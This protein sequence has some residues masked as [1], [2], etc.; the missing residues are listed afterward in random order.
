M[1]LK[2]IT[3][4]TYKIAI[5][6]YLALC[7]LALCAVVLY[8]PTANAQTATPTPEPTPTEQPCVIGCPEIEYN[9][10]YSIPQQIITPWVIS[11]TTLGPAIIDRL[12]SGCTYAGDA[13]PPACPQGTASDH[14]GTW[15]L[16]SGH[17]PGTEFTWEP[18][19]Y[20]HAEKA[21]FTPYQPI[22]I[23]EGQ[24]FTLEALGCNS[25]SGRYY[26]LTVQTTGGWQERTT[27]LEDGFCRSEYITI[28]GPSVIFWIYMGLDLSYPGPAGVSANIAVW[29]RGSIPDCGEDNSEFNNVPSQVVAGKTQ[30][31]YYSELT[32][33]TQ[34]I[35][36]LTITGTYRFLGAAD[37]IEPAWYHYDYGSEAW[38]VYGHIYP[39]FS[40]ELAG[41]YIISATTLK[42][43]RFEVCTYNGSSAW[44]TSL[45][46]QTP[47]FT[48]TITPTSTIGL[49]TTNISDTVDWTETNGPCLTL[50][51]IDITTPFSL[52]WEGINIC[53]RLYTLTKLTVGANAIFSGID[54]LPYALALLNAGGVLL[55]YQLVRKR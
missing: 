46:T 48:P 13:Y 53:T 52:T 6:I 3:R 31:L 45:I 49:P 40:S 9:S 50:G 34:Q 44:T 16:G 15:A 47:P 10:Y 20:L 55:T 8:A 23:P 18:N 1:T 32:S 37:S 5:P 25:K 36:L 42:N 21:R 41:T 22:G 24:S 38:D 2:H 29:P 51:P 33:A 27:I 11:D 30:Y 12:D 7:A 43:A 17:E 19:D 54:L 26:A 28:T 4:Q 14:N 39:G 35:D